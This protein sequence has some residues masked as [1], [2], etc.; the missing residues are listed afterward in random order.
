MHRVGGSHTHFAIDVAETP[1]GASARD[2]SPRADE[3][4]QEQEE[5]T[6]RKVV[7]VPR[8]ATREPKKDKPQSS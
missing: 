4:G 6:M 5:T 7:A 1:S 8:D 2:G 3:A